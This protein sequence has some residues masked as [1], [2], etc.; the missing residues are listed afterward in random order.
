[1]TVPTAARRRD[2]ALLVRP[3]VRALTAYHLDQVP[4][5][6]KL[7]QNECPWEPPRRIK[8]E[9]AAAIAAAPWVS[10]PDFHGDALRRPLGRRFGWPAEGILVG[11][12]SNELLATALAAVAGAGD[13]VLGL[14]PSFGLYPALAERSGARYRALG[15]RADLALPLDELE[16]E[17]ERNPRRPVVL[18]SPNNP[19]GEAVPPERVARLAGRLDAPLLLDNAYAEFCRFDYRPLLDEHPNLVLFRTFS[20]AWGLAG[21]RLGY[22]LARPELVA[23][24]IKVKLP[25]NLG[26]AGIAAGRAAL[27][28]EGA[29]ARR[30]RA[31]IGRR[32]QWRRL[33]ERFGLEVLPSEANFLLVR[34]GERARAIRDGLAARGILVRDVSHGPGL[35]GCLRVSIGGGPALRAVGRALVEI[36]AEEVR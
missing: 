24:L 20:K 19:T 9:V 11:N 12:G 3:A 27:A 16:T 33:L 6:F 29:T 28:A 25:Y 26:H 7:D 10:Y 30:V 35:A 18:C 32:P 17:V 13:E 14:A 31:V 2:P 4:C 15:P 22:L 21:L 34:C 1:V 8:L 36:A 5:R 23:E